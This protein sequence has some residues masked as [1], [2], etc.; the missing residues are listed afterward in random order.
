MKKVIISTT[1]FPPEGALEEFDNL[2]DWTLVVAGDKKTPKDF[3]L[4]NGIYLSPED[5]EKL[6]KYLSDAIGWNCIQRRNMA[7][8]MAHK[9]GADVI[10][11]I[12]SD[13][14]RHN[15]WGQNIPVGQ[16]IKIREYQT[17]L[18][19]F[20]PIGEATEFKHLWHRGFPLQLLRERKNRELKIVNKKVDVI[21]SYWDGEF[22]VDAM[23]RLEHDTFGVFDR[24]NFP[25]TSNKWSPFNSQNTFFTKD[26]LPYF[27]MF[28]FVGRADDIICGYYIQSKGFN[29][30]YFAP[31]VTQE[32]NPHDFTKDMVN[33]FWMYENLYKILPEMKKDSENWFKYLPE[34]TKNAYDLYR[35]HF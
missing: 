30:G 24:S 27:F 22:D 15:D 26:V 5:Q 17:N 1:I 35:R 9:L 31:T 2:K 18:D 4:K 32:R 12:D 25:F 34:Q 10:S 23:C 7:L 29:V 6:D 20:D 13:N 33:E 16:T 28:P 14:Y 19:I 8:L 3:K 21:S 11:S